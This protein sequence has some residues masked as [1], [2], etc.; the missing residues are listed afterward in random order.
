VSEPSL[1][2]YTFCGWYLDKQYSKKL[3]TD[4]VVDVEE[5]MMLYAKWEQII[6]PI[7]VT[8][9]LIYVGVGV[10]AVGIIVSVVVILRKQK[11]KD[12]FDMGN[13]L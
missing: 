4:T 8:E 9:I 1:S 3:Q 11:Q 7:N 5:Q 10:V 12:H 13:K 6:E 2:G